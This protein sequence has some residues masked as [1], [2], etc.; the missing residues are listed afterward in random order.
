MGYD[1]ALK[2]VE[3]V[4]K[5][6]MRLPKY[7]RQKFYCDFNIINYNE[8]EMNLEIFENWLDE[9]IY[10]MNNSLVLI[11]ETE[12]KKKQQVNKDHQKTTKDNIRDFQKI[13]TEALQ[14][15]QTRKTEVQNQRKTL[16]VD[17][18]TKVIRFHTAKL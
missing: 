5:A 12:I 4:T 6:V 16:D 8:R 17:Y 14:L 11:V 10:D 2:S 13:I 1:G 18:R 3:N 9:R 7:L 15:P